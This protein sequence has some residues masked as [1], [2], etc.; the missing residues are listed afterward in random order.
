MSVFKIDLVN[1]F[2]IAKT[3]DQKKY[4]V[5]SLAFNTASRL[6]Y[7]GRDLLS[8]LLGLN[9]NNTFGVETQKVFLS[10]SFHLKDQLL[11]FFYDFGSDF[12]L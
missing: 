7:V 4:N 10:V 12:F 2:I 3:T 9:G 8:Y 5:C 6:L 11:C 1:V